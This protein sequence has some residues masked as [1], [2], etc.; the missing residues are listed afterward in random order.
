MKN[1]QVPS[2]T[3]TPPTVPGLPLLGALSM[4][5]KDMHR[6][7]AARHET[8]GDVYLFRLGRTRVW[9]VRDPDA[10]GDVLVRQRDVWVKTGS[11]TY[12][13]I[14]DLIGRG[15]V[16]SDGPAWLRQRRLS[17]PA[18]HKER[19]AGLSNSMV[20]LAEDVAVR[21]EA[22]LPA[23]RSS[24]SPTRCCAIRRRSSPPRCSRSTCGADAA[25]DSRTPSIRACAPPTS[26]N[27]ALRG[28]AGEPS[29]GCRRDH[30][31]EMRSSRSLSPGTKRRRICCRGR[32]SRLPFLAGNRK[33][34]GDAFAM[35]EAKIVLAVL[36]PR[37]RLVLT[38][39]PTEEL[40]ITL[41][42]REGLMARIERRGSEA[43]R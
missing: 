18:F 20:R 27:R 1:G 26:N 33:C 42:P 21:F 24:T 11:Q 36:V 5:G 28:S 40:A 15:L 39:R 17:T 43:Q 35:A 14:A 23:A 6:R 8:L 19:I 12:D 9:S 31:R 10:I 30:R 16:T 4:L 2:T 29:C 38:A 22:G 25:V 7:I 3:V 13:V 37:F 34:I 32:C 41:G